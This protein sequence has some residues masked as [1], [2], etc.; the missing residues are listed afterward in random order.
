MKQ[1]AVGRIVLSAFVLS[2]SLV[3]ASWGPFTSTGTTTGVGN[4]S[5]APVT[6]NQ[7]PNQVVCAVRS[8]K[9]ELMVNQFS[10][11]TT[12]GKWTSLSGTVAS[13]PSCTNNGA[14][15]VLCAA[16]A[17]NGD[18]QWAIFN[19]SSWT[20]TAKVSGSLYS[21]PSC[22]QYT[23]GEVLCVARNSSGGLDW[24]LYNGTAW[25]AFASLV[26]TAISA[27]GCTTDDN[28]GVVC[29]LVTAGSSV[30]V[31]RF[32][33]GAW[34]GFL[35]LGG[36]LEGQPTCASWN[37]NGALDCF[38]LGTD[39]VIYADYFSGGTW[40]TS[41]WGGFYDMGTEYLFDNNGSCTSEAS[42]DM[43]CAAIGYSGAFY[44]DANFDGWNPIGGT[45]FVGIP[46]G[47]PLGTGEAIFVIMGADNQLSS[48]V[49]P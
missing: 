45:T 8:G 16:T 34:E 12:W 36:T 37:S 20:K 30:L 31:N 9:A 18:L 4:P 43:L 42:G 39:D 1:L 11:G 29:A 25:S 6:T 28:G 40:A 2:S 35:S 19:G 44:A 49:G 24:S 14:S 33:A 7:T 26:T 15:E 5:C 3:W 27:P 22:A 17:T 10:N 21:A 46:S 47:A 41:S 13:D 32:A 48:V 23:A 38:F